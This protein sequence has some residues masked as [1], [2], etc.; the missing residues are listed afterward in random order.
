M[1]IDHRTGDLT[2]G[3]RQQFSKQGA[4]FMIENALVGAGGSVNPEATDRIYE[5]KVAEGHDHQTAS[6]TWLY[7]RQS[8][9]PGSGRL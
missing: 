9:L 3:E 4:V 7:P 5:Q 8:A 1:A 6:S 2:D